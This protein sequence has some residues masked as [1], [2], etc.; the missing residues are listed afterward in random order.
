M[1]IEWE[2]TLSSS[3]VEK[4]EDVISKNISDNMDLKNIP[5]EL[6]QPWSTF[7]LKTKLPSIILEKLIKI[8]DEIIE[9]KESAN[10]A[11]ENLAGQIEDEFMIDLDIIKQEDLMEYLLKVCKLYTIKAFCQNDPFNTEKIW[12]E[13]WFAKIMSIWLVSQKD[14]EYNPL[15]THSNCHL[16][17]VMY[18]KIPEYLPSRKNSEL[19]DDGTISFINNVSKDTCFGKSVIKFNPKVGDFYIFP[20]SQGHTVYPFRTPD[21]KGERRSIS[22]NAVFSSETEQ[23]AMLKVQQEMNQEGGEIVHSLADSQRR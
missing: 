22:F 3:M 4:P 21:G 15:H 17:S 9:N 6:F 18:L 13:R 11:D 20:A 7:V 8:T 19:G 16:S 12:K 23:T 14:N 1:L 5:I 2:N 10:R